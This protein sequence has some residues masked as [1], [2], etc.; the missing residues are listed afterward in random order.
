MKIR[1]DFVTNSSSSS[2]VTFSIE[3]ETLAK[4]ISEYA[5]D[6]Y[7][8]TIISVNGNTVNGEVPGEEG[9]YTSDVKEE[10][11]TEYLLSI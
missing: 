2:F 1:S 9:I 3:D 5:N 10:G 11:I 8:S 6:P 7:L 4:V